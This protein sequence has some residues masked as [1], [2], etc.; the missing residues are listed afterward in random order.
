MNGLTLISL[1]QLRAP[2]IDGFGRTYPEYKVKANKNI[3]PIASAGAGLEND[4]ATAR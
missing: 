4:T 3:P 1:I 2:I